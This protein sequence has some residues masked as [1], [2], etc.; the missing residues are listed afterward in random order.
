MNI[1]RNSVTTA[2][3]LEHLDVF[4]GLTSL[5]LTGRHTGGAALFASSVNDPG[6]FVPLHTHTREDEL[7]YILEG[8]LEITLGDRKT[9]AAAGTSAFLPR[10]VPHAWRVVGDKSVKFL[11][12]VTPSGMEHMFREFA[13]LPP[14]A[15]DPVVMS[16]ICARYGISF[17]TRLPAET[18]L[19]G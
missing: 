4:G 18:Q 12:T 11:V 8:R 2:A 5:H 19:C 6:V 1:A 14:G 9:V 13:A 17:A 10:G 16:G 3:Q 7:Y 15:P